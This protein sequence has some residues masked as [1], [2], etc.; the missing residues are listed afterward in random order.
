MTSASS[1]IIIEATAAPGLREPQFQIQHI[2]PTNGSDAMTS[3]YNLLREACGISQAEAAEYIH[4]T[5]ID[6][7]K[8]WSS[9]RRPAPSWAINQLQALSRGIQK[10]GTEFAD[11]LMKHSKGNVFVIGEPLDDDDARVCGFPSSAAQY[12]AIAI[13]ISILPDDAEIR[14]TPRVRGSIPAPLLERTRPRPTNTDRQ[15]LMSTPF[16]VSSSYS[17]PPNMNLRKYERLE[18]IGWIKSW[19]KPT[20]NSVEYHLTDEG[21]AM[22]ALKL[23]DHVRLTN[24]QTGTF[25]IHK[26]VGFSQG[27]GM[28]PKQ[29]VDLENIQDPA[30]PV[31]KET[32]EFAVQQWTPE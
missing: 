3:V 4:M 29:Y 19:K 32:V 26:V 27:P 23:G 14:V 13:A 30:A 31:V 10:A 16:G 12:Q 11:M 21:K 2:K 7:V 15:V 5:R 6:T 24:Q 8:S 28:F 9:D 18:E 22:R 20:M 1:T 17:P 25:M